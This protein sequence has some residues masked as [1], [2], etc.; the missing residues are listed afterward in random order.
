MYL[1]YT[2]YL[3]INTKYKTFR[4]YELRELSNWRYKTRNL[5]KREIN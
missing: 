2:I 5:E 1:N 3:N 4:L